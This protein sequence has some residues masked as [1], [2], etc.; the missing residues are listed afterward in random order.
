MSEKSL[1]AFI[2]SKVNSSI[3]EEQLV[4]VMNFANTKI[5]DY[6]RSKW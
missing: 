2:E 5:D 3:T 4:Y 1:C 6:N